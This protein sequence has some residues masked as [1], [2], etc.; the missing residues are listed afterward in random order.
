MQAK[1]PTFSDVEI[2][3]VAVEDGL[4]HPGD[5]SDLVVEI[6]CVVAPD[7]VGN[8][9]GTVEA[10]EEK[11]VCRDGLCFPCLADHEELRKDSHGLQLF[12][13]SKGVK[14]WFSRN[15]RPVTG[16][17]RNSRRKESFS[18]SNVFRNFT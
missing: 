2:E 18:L 11:V 3:E 16:T 5:N 4:Y 8:V 9:E 13:T 17:S 15:D 12:L 14:L 10:Q 6:L 7:P 1:Q